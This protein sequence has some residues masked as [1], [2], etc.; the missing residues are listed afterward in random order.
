MSGMLKICVRVE[1]HTL[2][3]ECL[4]LLQKESFLL[5]LSSSGLKL[6]LAGVLSKS[7]IMRTCSHIRIGVEWKVMDS[8]FS[9]FRSK[10][11]HF[12]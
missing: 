9:I 12:Y 3:D 11:V 4:H 1:R 7:I 8:E 5:V 10:N 6:C 2:K